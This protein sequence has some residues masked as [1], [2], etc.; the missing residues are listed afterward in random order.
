M[1]RALKK[2][3]QKRPL[4]VS[5]RSRLVSTSIMNMIRNSLLPFKGKSEGTFSD[6]KDDKEEGKA[7][8]T[9]QLLSVVFFSFNNF[10]SFLE[11]DHKI[12]Q[13]KMDDGLF[14]P[15]LPTPILCFDRKVKISFFLQNPYLDLRWRMTMSFPREVKDFFFIKYHSMFIFY[16]IC[17]FPAPKILTGQFL[18]KLRML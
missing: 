11:S 3:S 9:R 1:K 17:C 12:Y 18:V 15:L 7:S 8:Y 16:L 13:M 10:L 6:E 2:R 4:L 5:L 14:Y